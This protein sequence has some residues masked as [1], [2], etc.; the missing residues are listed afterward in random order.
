V[1]DGILSAAFG[2]WAGR[3]IYAVAGWGFSLRLLCLKR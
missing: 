2:R 1:E 3:V